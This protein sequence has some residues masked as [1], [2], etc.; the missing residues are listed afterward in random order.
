MFRVD[1]MGSVELVKGT[2]QA[3]TKQSSGGGYQGTQAPTQRAQKLSKEEKKKAMEGVN[4]IGASQYGPS[5]AA[6]AE[7]ID[8]NAPKPAK[9][10]M[11][12]PKI[13]EAMQ[14]QKGA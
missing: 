12:D 14:Q 10:D 2:T 6:Q 1:K 3:A 13:W 8:P 11:R 4:A 7:K 5:A 9:P